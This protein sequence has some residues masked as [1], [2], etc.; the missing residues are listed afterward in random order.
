MKRRLI[1]S[2]MV[3]VMLVFNLAVSAAHAMAKSPW[4]FS[5]FYMADTAAAPTQ[6]LMTQLET[7]ILPELEKILLPDQI[8]QFQSKV[9]N[10]SSFRKAFKSLML[11]PEQKAQLKALLS[12]MVKKDAFASLTPEQKKRLF[13]KKKELLK[14][15]SEEITGKINAN[16][17][18]GL[19][20]PEG[21][22]EKIDVVMKKKDS[23][24][25]N[26][27]VIL[28]KIETGLGG[29]P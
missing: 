18:E 10:G 25:P 19:A 6:D 23:F 7:K 28:G 3:C 12:S 26:P 11:K 16:L 4:A 20:L 5:A 14:P 2:M 9:A 1:L 17:K 8:E 15:T 21:M 24:I 27:E 22:I 29:V 13:M